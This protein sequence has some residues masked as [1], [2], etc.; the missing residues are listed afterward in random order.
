MTKTIIITESQLKRLVESSNVYNT[1]RDLISK[2]Y[3]VHG[4]NADF[5]AFSPEYIR[6]G[7]RAREGYGA[8][9]TDTAYKAEEYGTK[10]KAV[11][12][13]IF[14]FIEL[15]A[16]VEYGS[17]LY[18]QLFGNDERKKKRQEIQ[19]KID[20]LIDNDRY[21]E[22]LDLYDELDKLGSSIDDDYGVLYGSLRG[23]CL[24][25]IETFGAKNLGSLQYNIMN[26]QRNLP[27]LANALIKLGYDGGH[28]DNVYT[29]WNFEKLNQNIK[30]II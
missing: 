15:R 22:A 23:D 24:E 11:K 29:I 7:S 20:F 18:F 3:L 5:N 17:E 2:G 27:L 26:P 28:D 4:T 21:R 19:T 25:A 9:F 12:K 16:S 1:C 6:G 8:Y 10:I 14:N 13:N 30:T